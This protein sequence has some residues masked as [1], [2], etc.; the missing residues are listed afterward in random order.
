MKMLIIVL[1]ALLVYSAS[2]WLHWYLIC[3]GIL[4]WLE[5]R[6][7]GAAVPSPEDIRDSATEVLKIKLGL[8]P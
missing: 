2:R 1:T 5:E 7:G 4:K 3:G 8:K 6:F